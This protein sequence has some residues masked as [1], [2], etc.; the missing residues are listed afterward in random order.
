M[1]GIKSGEKF[2]KRKLSLMCMA[3]LLLQSVTFADNKAKEKFGK[4]EYSTIP[5]IDFKDAQ[6]R[7]DWFANPWGGGKIKAQVRDSVGDKFPWVLKVTFQDTKAT[8][9]NRK[10]FQ[11]LQTKWKEN[12][13]TGFYC[14]YRA[15]DIKGSIKFVYTCSDDGKHY[16]FT[17]NTGLKEDGKWHMLKFQMGGWNKENKHFNIKNLKDINFTFYGSGKFEIGEIGMLCSYRKLSGILKPPIKNLSVPSGSDKKIDGEINE[18]EI[19]NCARL[20]LTLPSS[21]NPEI[22]GSKAPKDKTEIYLSQTPK[23]LYGA[24]RCFKKDMKKLRANFTEDAVRIWEDECI[25]FYFDPE[26]KMAK[27]LMKKYAINANGKTGIA[28]FKDR[29]KALTV[30]SKKF[31]NRWETEFF[32]PWKTLEIKPQA[33][34]A[35][36]FNATRTTYDGEKMK[37]RTG[38]TTPVW[39]AIVDFGV[40]FIENNKNLKKKT[41]TKINE[42]GLVGRGK[43]IITGTTPEGESYKLN[44]HSPSGKNHLLDKAGK[45]PQNSFEIP[46]QFPIKTSGYYSFNLLVY[47]KTGSVSNYA[48]GRISEQATAD[49]KPLKIDQLALFPEPKIFKKSKGTFKIQSGMKYYIASEKLSFCGEKIAEELKKFYDVSLGK[50]EIPTNASILIDLNIASQIA[51]NIIKEN[52]LEDDF[53]K[54]KNDGFLLLVS[55]KN[56]FITA[57]EKRGV[58]YG[59]NALLDLV[60]M[61]AGDAGEPAISN[62]KVVDWPDLEYRYWF[63]HMRGYMPKNKYNVSLYENMLRK[64]PL[65]FRYNAF[66]LEPD[67]YY[68]WQHASAF[69]G[70]SYAWD[71]SEFKRVISFLHNNCVPVMPAVQSHGHMNWL[72]RNKDYANLREDG[73]LHTLCTGHPDS[74]KTLFGFYDEMLELCSENPEYKP[75]HFVVQLD[76]V[77]WKTRGT[78]EEKRCKYCKD[79]PKN[80]IYIDHIKKVSKYMKKKNI[81]PIMWSDMMVEEHN[82][83]NEFKCV[84]IRDQLPKNMIMGHWSMSDYQ[85][86]PRFDKLGLE[87]W[88]TSTGYH[89]SRLNEKLISGRMFLIWTYY[90]WLSETRCKGQGS[91][92]LMAQALYA[93]A[94]W[95]MFPDNDNSTWMKYTQIYGNWLM[96]NWSRKPLPHAS[97]QFETVDISEIANDSVIDDKAGD[98]K[99][100]FDCGPGKDLSLLNLKIKN[101]HGVPVKFAIK[102]GQAAFLKFNKLEKKSAELAVNRKAGSLILLHAANLTNEDAGIKAFRNKKIYG[103]PLKG[104]AVARYTVTYDDGKTK[105][106]DALFGWNLSPWNYNPMS[107]NEVLAK[108][109]IDARS[110]LEGKTK[111]AK[112]K[113]LP[114]DIALYQYEWPNPRPYVPIK[115]VKIESLG[116]YVSYGLLA[117]TARG[118]KQD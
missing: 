6:S 102:D 50:T 104:K 73:D 30:A 22:C 107:K 76:E 7:N 69:K 89:I 68:Q 11:S 62:V 25:E 113:N 94:C 49:W 52:E 23:G 3:A 19:K 18:E 45:L 96:R 84:E 46:F 44:V 66:F 13:V 95:N 101:V 90:W 91:Y 93:N 81:K 33:P 1:V 2:M 57:K 74:Y 28:N 38:W 31:D 41:G 99:G 14:W 82:G 36:G 40:A 42:F 100:W 64:I 80:K 97:N 35:L 32:I 60:K 88:K 10:L 87:S 78:P 16:T 112:A 75:T 61:T 56:I 55:D 12:A 67:D 86:I 116:S 21:I 109:V 5:L 111:E 98:G 85:S 58:L 27:K 8:L 54:I 48:E 43:Y 71:L 79:I 77:R 37:E 4:N 106:F 9:S 53:K 59:V 63:S 39:N 65:H 24:A 118:S 103:D 20:E 105:T 115:S 114:N 47:D 26:R 70:N 29:N 92:G 117:I 110:I 108:Y 51:Q 17:N 83:L 34:F 15:S 72:L